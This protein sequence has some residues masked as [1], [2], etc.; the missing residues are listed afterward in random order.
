MAW[1]S[2]LK[3]K[4]NRYQNEYRRKFL[5]IS[6]KYNLGLTYQEINENAFAIADIKAK[7]DLTWYQGIVS[8]DAWNLIG[9]IFMLVFAVV[10]SVMSLGQAAILSF[11][12][13]V[14]A[15]SIVAAVAG[16]AANMAMHYRDLRGSGINGLSLFAEKQLYVSKRRN[17]WAEARNTL[18]TLMVYGG[19]DI[20]ANG[21]IY[22]QGAAGSETFSNS[23]AYDTTRGMRGILQEDDLDEMVHSRTGGYLAG[24][25][26][27]HDSVLN[28]EMPLAK[29]TFGAPQIEERI[30]GTFL[31]RTRE[32][33]D[34]FVE[35]SNA[36][37][38]QW[39]GQAIYDRI[40]EEQTKSIK[41]ELKTIDFLYKIK[42]Y[43][44]NLRADFDYKDEKFFIV[45]EREENIALKNALTGQEDFYE[46]MAS[47]KISDEDKAIKYVNL[48]MDLMSVIVGTFS[49]GGDYTGNGGDITKSS[50][51][52]GFFNSNT[53][54][55]YTGK[56]IIEIYQ[57]EFLPSFKCTFYAWYRPEVKFTGG[58]TPGGWEYRYDT[59][60]FSSTSY[61][62]FVARSYFDVT[63]SISSAYYTLASFFYFRS[64]QYR[65]GS[66]YYWPGESYFLSEIES[67]LSLNDGRL[68]GNRLGI[69]PEQLKDFDFSALTFEV[70]NTESD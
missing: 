26:Y 4:R 62:W 12:M 23:L 58:T 9:S 31:R 69:V 2:P 5:A 18:T 16:F 38:G 59:P 66:G 6:L 52:R 56:E 33:N 30:I 17:A 53:K 49:T 65:Y 34:A 57:N 43:N 27:F 24:G 45:K 22:K 37:F 7:K 51:C 42:N 11:E 67:I 14:A 13:L 35:L 68:T 41:A 40:I 3:I 47:D 36:E 28:V 50:L 15:F 64:Y 8:G 21:R 25:E 19:Y 46:I 10:I 29:F 48:L 70:N 1:S 63:M 55:T 54:R 20:Y 32:I 44:K 61:G 60:C 39:A